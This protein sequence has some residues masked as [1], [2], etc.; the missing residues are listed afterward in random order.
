MIATVTVQ[1]CENGLGFVLPEKVVA[2]LRLQEGDTLYIVPQDE[3][4]P[5]T[6]DLR[7]ARFMEAYQI[8]SK[9]YRNALRELA[10]S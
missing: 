4:L 2:R 7:H 3:H 9:K 10:D 6:T 8:G 1:R 5:V